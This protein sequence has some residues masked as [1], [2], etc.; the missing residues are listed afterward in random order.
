MEKLTLHTFENNTEEVQ[1]NNLCSEL[2]Q[3]MIKHMERFACYGQ[4][5]VVFDMKPQE[6][7]FKEKGIVIDKNLPYLLQLFNREKV[8]GILKERLSHLTLVIT[9]EERF[10]LISWKTQKLNI[11]IRV[12]AR[13]LIQAGYKPSEGDLFKRILVKLQFAI[14]E[15]K[16]GDSKQ[17]QLSW[18][19]RHF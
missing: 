16:V 18:I 8:L 1:L 11:N 19:K 5:Q 3:K 2:I 17:S 15:G 12:M 10:W 4:T 6:I 9:D 14:L 13:D 7:T